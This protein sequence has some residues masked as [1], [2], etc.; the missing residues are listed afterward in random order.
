MLTGCGRQER[1]LLVHLHEV[2][3]E[4][5]KLEAGGREKRGRGEL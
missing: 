1:G 3:M 4:E 5:V 2:T